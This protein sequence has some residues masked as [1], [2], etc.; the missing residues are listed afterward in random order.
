MQ[1]SAHIACSTPY[2]S[3]TALLVCSTV[4]IQH[5]ALCIVIYSICGMQHTRRL[6]G[7]YWQV[8]LLPKL[9]NSTQAP[10]K[11]L[12]PRIAVCFRSV[13]SMDAEHC[14]VL[15]LLLIGWMP[16][17]AVFLLCCLFEFIRVVWVQVSNLTFCSGLR[18]R[19][20]LWLLQLQ[21]PCSICM[22]TT[23]LTH[24]TA[25]KQRCDIN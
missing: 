6:S 16:S 24:S 3:L 21:S 22:E 17:I 10:S 23:F 19:G 1:L 14:R 4:H 11:T 15:A 18:T 2:M 9:D 25:R 7:C 20:S 8:E 13:Y 12:V 5:V